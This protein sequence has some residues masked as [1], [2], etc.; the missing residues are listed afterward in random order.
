MSSLFGSLSEYNGRNQNN[1]P[2][3]RC[4][5]HRHSN[6]PLHRSKIGSGYI[7][8]IARLWRATA[9]Y[10][11]WYWTG[12]AVSRHRQVMLIILTRL[13]SSSQMQL[14]ERSSFA[15]VLMVSLMSS[16]LIGF[17]LW[18]K[19]SYIVLQITVVIDAMFASL[20]ETYWD[21]M[22]ILTF[23]SNL[24]FGCIQI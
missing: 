13:P 17:V 23:I 21:L 4:T 5:S 19:Y 11:D 10:M 6:Q 8:F 16:W 15:N 1:S 7:V 24:G 9:I 20:T 3:Y 12:I 2:E 22:M 18:A 14:T